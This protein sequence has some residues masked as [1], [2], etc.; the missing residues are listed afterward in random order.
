MKSTTDQETTRPTLL[1]TTER[2]IIETALQLYVGNAYN[3]TPE[4]RKEVWGEYGYPLNTEDDT[5][6]F[7]D[8][9][10]GLAERVARLPVWMV[11]TDS[12][13]HDVRVNYLVC[14][15]EG[16]A[17]RGVEAEYE[18]VGQ[19]VHAQHAEH[20]GYTDSETLMRLVDHD[21][22]WFIDT[23]AEYEAEKETNEEN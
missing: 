6:A 19:D 5:V 10:Y 4:E 16:N 9:V 2:S 14:S 18:D 3:M 8:A 22:Q 13:L 23:K 11:V 1:T 20:V 15:S 17:L 7:V 12:E 21:L